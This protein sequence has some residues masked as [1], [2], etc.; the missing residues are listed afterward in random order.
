MPNTV[1]GAAR[2]V[3]ELEAEDPHTGAR[4]GLLHTAHGTIATPVFMPVGTQATVKTLTQ[5]DLVNLRAQIVLSNAYH[6]YLRPGADLIDRAGGLHRFMNWGGP[7][8]TDSGGYQVFSLSARNRISEDGVHFQS[9]L[10]GSYHL[11]SPERVMEIEH[12]LGADIIM[13][14]DECIAYPSTPEYAAASVKMTLRWADRCMER[15]QQLAAERSHRPCPLLFGIVQGSIYPELRQRCARQLVALDLPGYAIGG[16]AVGEPRDRMLAVVEATVSE[17][18]TNKPRYLMGVGL[19]HD[20]VDA[21]SRGVDMFD[22]VVP[23]RN[24]RNGTAFTHTGRVRLKN[25]SLA[26][27][28]APLEAG[29]TCATCQHYSRA[30]LRHLFQSGEILGMRLATYHNLHFYLTL[31]AEMRQ[32]IIKGRFVAWRS[33]FLERFDPG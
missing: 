13:V 29:C 7:I 30:Y 8:L 16:T 31:M 2:P 25:A 1:G 22:C 14:L 21:V 18:P 6:L 20:L 11:F 9:H 32:A 23:T 28:L 17:L 4:A 12:A 24:A 27:E 15:H 10:D 5:Q 26:E 19:P 3:F 33:R